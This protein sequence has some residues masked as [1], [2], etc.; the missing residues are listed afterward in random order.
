MFLLTTR[1]LRSQRWRHQRHRVSSDEQVRHRALGRFNNLFVRLVVDLYARDHL[2]HVAQNHIQVLI[3]RLC[4]ATRKVSTPWCGR[5]SR[6]R[7]RVRARHHRGRGRDRGRRRRWVRVR[8]Q[9]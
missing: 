7:V 8:K 2:L 4:R 6:V 3:V 9:I 5:E 1:R